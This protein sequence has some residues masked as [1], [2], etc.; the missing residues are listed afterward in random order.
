FTRLAVRHPARPPFAPFQRR[1]HEF[2]AYAHA[3]VFVL[4]HHR[5]VSVAVV[6]AVISLLDQRP[7]FFFFFLL[8]VNKL[9][10]VGVP[11]LER[12]HLRRAARFAAAFHH[13]RYLIVNLQ[14]RQRP[15]WLATPAQFFSCR[16]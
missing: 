12:V 8:G 2:V 13:I 6:A 11:I 5:A 15:A 14:K 7:R 4:I 10:D 16:P 1:L 3:H 9:F